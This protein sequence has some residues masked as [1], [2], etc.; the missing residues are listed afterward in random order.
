MKLYSNEPLYEL[1]MIEKRWRIYEPAAPDHLQ[2]YKG[3]SPTLAQI[4][5]NRGLIEPQDA[6]E[7]L[8]VKDIRTDPFSMKDMEKA[9]HRI[10]KAIQNDE[11][12]AVYGDF[13][14]DGVTATTLMMEVLTAL[15]AD[16]RAY[17]PDRVD[18]GYGLNSPALRKLAMD[19]VRLVVTV[20]CGIRA[21]Q[22]IA[23]GNMAGL[24]IIVTDHHSIGPEL[25]DA[26]AVVNPQQEDCGGDNRIAGVGV[27]FMVARALMLDGYKRKGNGN[28][29]PYQDLLNRLLDLVAI[30]TVADIMALNASLNRA[31][32]RHGIERMNT[33]PRPGLQALMEIS[34]IKPGQMDA[35]AI[36]FGLGPRINAAGRLA[37]ALTAYQLLSANSIEEA[38][39]LAL[40]LQ[41][42]NLQRQEL[43]R[44]A[45]DRI[46]NQIEQ[47]HK[48]SD[49]LIFAVDD[50]VPQGIVGLVA[51]RLTEAHYRPSI[52][53]ERGEQESHASCRS[54]PEFHITQA[55]DACSDLLVR[56]GGH[57]MAA[58]LTIRN[59]NIPALRERLAS[60][61]EKQ[62]RDQQLAPVIDID[63]EMDLGQ[64]NGDLIREL[65]VL[66]PTG[67][68]NG[69]P[70]FMT[71]NLRVVEARNV[72][73]DRQHLKLTVR[74]DDQPPIDCIAFRMGDQADR[75]ADR[76]D[77]AYFLEINEWQG[78]QNLQL[79]VQALRPSRN[80]M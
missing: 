74:S 65:K 47:D 18:E 52:V 66:E 69:A 4:L 11:K 37:S 36:G 3:M 51:G 79:N 40:K 15:K 2:R 62:L 71:R 35:T 45:V 6:Y 27:A 20:D 58:G 24:D 75:L 70:V 77:L 38:A 72:G 16:V 59:E 23:D 29:K 21:V 67:H 46:V 1:S 73:S 26:Y 14:A 42:L 56:H 49:H 61:A 50:Q 5:Y 31:L 48:S 76:I 28:I 32:V 22:E 19:G 13:D 8:Y 25:P 54:I 53:L 68:H 34:G 44:S 9:V 57:A 30:G 17:I 78:R 43:T 63:M 12:I 39:P 7:F 10:R 33:D 64:L 41:Q 80:G 55:L 60:L